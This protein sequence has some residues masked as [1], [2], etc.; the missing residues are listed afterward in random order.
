[1]QH[2]TMSSSAP[3]PQAPWLM[4]AGSSFSMSEVGAFKLWCLGPSASPD[5]R[6]Q[7]A[8]NGLAVMHALRDVEAQPV[9]PAQQA[10]LLRDH[11]RQD[12]LCWGFKALAL[13]AG[14]L[15]LCTPGPLPAA[16]LSLWE[17]GPGADVL[18]QL[19]DGGVPVRV[20]AAVLA[21]RCP[22]LHAAVAAER[23]RVCQVRQ[24]CSARRMLLE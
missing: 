12:C 19:R 10:N 9:N 7:L 6:E 8:Q 14:R 4:P 20:H 18:L 3:H 23:Q 2:A 11:M 5:R 13:A 16:A 22:V 15:D 1:M 21:A 17:L 24:V